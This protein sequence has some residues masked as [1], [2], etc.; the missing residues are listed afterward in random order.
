MEWVAGEWLIQWVV[1]NDIGVS[2]EASR[3]V[4]PVG[5]EFVLKTLLVIVKSTPEV[6]ALLRGVVEPEVFGLAVLNERVTV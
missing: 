3:G 4:V 2:S 1:S 5:D 6:E